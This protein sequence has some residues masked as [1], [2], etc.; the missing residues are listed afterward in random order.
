MNICLLSMVGG[1][2]QIKKHYEYIIQ[3]TIYLE[4]CQY[5]P[6]VLAELTYDYCRINVPENYSY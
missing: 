5:M 1:N 3:F 4:L 6:K 2:I